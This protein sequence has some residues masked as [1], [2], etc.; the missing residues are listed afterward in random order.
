DSASTHTNCLIQLLK[1]GWLRSFVSTEARILQ[2]PLYLSSGYFK[3]FSKFP[4]QLQPLALRST[5]RCSLAGGEF[6]S[7]TTCCQLP[8]SPLSINFIEASST[9]T[10]S[11]NSL[12]IKEFFALSAPEEVRIIERFERPSTPNSRFI[13]KPA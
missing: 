5:S 6:Y 1:S 2:Q 10:E 13:P 4:L 12:I 11:S 8:F 9:P 3:K 7:V